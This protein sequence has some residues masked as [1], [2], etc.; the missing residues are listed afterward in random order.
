VPF[1]KEAHALNERRLPMELLL[2]IVILFLL[3]GGGLRFYRR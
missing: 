1:C 3:F 2:I